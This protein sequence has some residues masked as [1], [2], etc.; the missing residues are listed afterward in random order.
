MFT[1]VQNCGSRLEGST[2]EAA[3]H[4]QNTYFNNMHRSPKNKDALNEKHVFPAS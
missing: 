1:E 2:E 3:I 4:I